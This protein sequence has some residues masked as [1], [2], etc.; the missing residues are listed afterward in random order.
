MSHNFC[1]ALGCPHSCECLLQ[2]S[3]SPS[4]QRGKTVTRKGVGLL[5]KL[6][7]ATL[8]T[9]GLNRGLH[10]RCRFLLWYECLHQGQHVRVKLPCRSVGNCSHFMRNVYP[11]VGH[12]LAPL[13][14]QCFRLFV[15][16]PHKEA[17]ELLHKDSSHPC[18]AGV[19]TAACFYAPYPPH[20][21]KSQLTYSM[22][23][24]S[25]FVI[26]SVS[27][28]EAVLTTPDQYSCMTF[29]LQRRAGSG[30]MRRRD[31]QTGLI[32][33]KWV[34]SFTQ[35]EFWFFDARITLSG[36]FL[37]LVLWLCCAF[38]GSADSYTSRPSD[39]DVSLEED[40]EALRKEA[41]R[42]ALATLEKAKVQ[43][44][45][46]RII[47]QCLFIY[48]F[49]PYLFLT[50]FFFPPIMPA[51]QTS[52]ICRAHKCRLQPRPQRRC[53]CAGHGHFFWSQRLL[54]Y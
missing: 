22:K 12:F 2:I 36:L 6:S 11:S 43:D 16:L 21:T 24:R 45:C 3:G 28:L 52:G 14:C 19:N 9:H 50:S 39:S 5:Y 40:P 47:Q 18:G 33:I 20:I 31:E 4:A 17:V 15:I 26:M 30:L 49:C 1:L 51:D 29:G 42:Q 38:Q 54:A 37:F 35:R 25:P 23:G 46:G 8:Q 7:T 32:Q 13:L 10:R 27:L 34:F 53:S 44:D 41:D 48:L